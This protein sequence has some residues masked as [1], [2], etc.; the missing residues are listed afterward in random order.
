MDKKI[1]NGLFIALEGGEGSGKS[2]LAKKLSLYYTYQG[3]NVVL[4]RQPGG[5]PLGEKIRD[6]VV[7]NDMD[8]Y[9]QLMLFAACIRSGV[10]D[11]VKPALNEGSIVICDRYITSTLIYQGVAENVSKY[12]IM[13][14]LKAITDNLLPE[15][16]ILLDISAEEGLKRTKNSDRSNNKFDEKSIE[17]HTKINNAY[18]DTSCVDRQWRC[19]IDASKDADTVSYEVIRRIDSYIRYIDILR[20]NRYDKKDTYYV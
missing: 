6:I 12:K 13:T 16:E 9:M 17:F 5:T 7:N 20:Y 14:L 2:T 10:E 15:L 11:I 4:T 19:I 8:P 3:Y 18:K 1:K